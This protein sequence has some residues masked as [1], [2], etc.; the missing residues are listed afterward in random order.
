VIGGALIIG[1]ATW[2][3]RR[4]HGNGVMEPAEPAK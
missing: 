1:L 3:I 4:R 2:T